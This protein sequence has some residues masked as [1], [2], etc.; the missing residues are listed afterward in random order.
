M[1]LS[2]EAITRAAAASVKGVRLPREAEQR[3]REE[4]LGT[5][6]A[7]LSD[8]QFSAVVELLRQLGQYKRAASRLLFVRLEGISVR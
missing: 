1:H 3:A 5:L 6:V 7:A 2:L 4:V 8:E